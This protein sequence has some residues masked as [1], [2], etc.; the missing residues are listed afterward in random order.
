MGQQANAVLPAQAA[1]PLRHW[2]EAALERGRGHVER[3]WSAWCGR[4]QLASAGVRARNACDAEALPGATWHRVATHPLWLSTA[5]VETGTPADWLQAA[6]FG[7]ASAGSARIAHDVAAEAMA[8]LV[9]GLSQLVNGN[10]ND[11]HVASAGEAPSMGDARRWSG[12]LGV[13]LTAHADA[14]TLSLA[15]QI[16]DVV[17]ANICGSMRPA[18][19]PPR[20]SLSGVTD[21]LGGRRLGLRVLLQDTP[22]TLGSLKMLRIGDVL[23]LAH[24]LDQPLRVV[25]SHPAADAVPFCAAYLGSRGNYR[26]VELIPTVTAPQSSNP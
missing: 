9:R 25:A 12:A 8:D 7:A 2:P 3:I 23:P 15:L 24:R 26:A 17:A 18:P 10:A 1:R 14:R 22:L 11:K 19:E 5:S 6:L 20:G 16:G 4:W 13:Q 21:A